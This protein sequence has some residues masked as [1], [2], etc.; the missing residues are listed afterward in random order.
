[1]GGVALPLLA[2]VLAIGLGVCLWRLVRLRREAGRLSD[3]VE[4]FLADARAQPQINLRKDAL[5][6]LENS[7]AALQSRLLH[8]QS[9]MDVQGKQSRDMIVE[10]SHQLKTPLAS[11]R[12]YCEMDQAAHLPEQLAQIERMERMIA[13]L[14]R[15]EK[16][17]AGGVAF[18][19]QPCDLHVVA[20]EV[21][22]GIRPLYPRK[23]LLLEGEATLRCDAARMGEALVNLIKNA[24]EHTAPDGTV[25][26]RLT[27][28]EASVTLMV[29]DDGGGVP[30][31]DLPRLFERFFR[32]ARSSM[33]EGT[34][35]GLSIAREIVRLHHGT[36][37]AHNGPHGL[38]VL[39]TLPDLRHSLKKT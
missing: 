37:T 22:D 6:P 10:L 18:A 24:C 14:L 23:H 17:R 28:G 31:E 29:E 26:L 9:R 20:R 8:M 39:I 15:L 12:L 1:M 32:S 34:G 35:V 11:L 13:A 7:I 4:R 27:D 30:A 38:R 3:R 2:G 33:H 19:M 25:R 16:L 21:M 5:A 36:I